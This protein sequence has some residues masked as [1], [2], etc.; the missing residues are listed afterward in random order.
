M[1]RKFTPPDEGEVREYVTG[2]GQVAR[3]Y[4]VDGSIIGDVKKRPRRWDLDGAFGGDS[5]NSYT[6]FDKPVRFE[7]DVWVAGFKDGTIESFHRK[8]RLVPCGA[9]SL[10]KHTFTVVEGQFDDE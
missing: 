3:A 7:V 10:V 4:L 5:S 1:E 9:T 6:L 8:P 2:D